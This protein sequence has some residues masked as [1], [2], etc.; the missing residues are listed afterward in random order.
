MNGKLNQYPIELMKRESVETFGKCFI[1]KKIMK[2]ENIYSGNIIVIKAMIDEI[3]F[4]SLF[5]LFSSAIHLL[6]LH[7]K[8]KI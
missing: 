5:A 2:Q 6:L 7:G 3:V 1:P 8:R 4:S